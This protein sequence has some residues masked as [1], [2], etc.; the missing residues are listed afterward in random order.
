MST[1]AAAW[2][3][4]SL[5]ALSLAL[6]AFSLLLLVLNLSHPDVPIHPYWTVNTLLAMGFS[7]VGAVI[8]PR[9]SPHNPIGWLFCMVGLLWGV[10]HFSA[11]YAIYTLLAVPG[12]LPASKAAAWMMCWVWVPASGLIVFLLLLCPDGQLP[13][14]RWRLFA[15]FSLLLILVGVISQ[16]L[17]PGSVYYLGSIHNPLGVEGLPNVGE[18]VQTVVFTLIFVSAGSLFVRRLRA[19]GVERQQLKWFAYSSTLAISGVI[20]TYTISDAIG[21]LW[22]EWVGYVVLVVG[23]IGIPISMG[24]AI[25][26]YRLYEIDLL[27]NRT[28]VYGS[29]TAILTALYFGAIVLLQRLFV[30]LTGEKST[31]AVVASTLLIAALFSPLRRRIQSFIDRR[32]YRSK[33]DARKTLDAFSAKLRDETNLDALS[34]DLVGVVRETM[35]PAHVSLWLRSSEDGRRPEGNER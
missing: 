33:Y 25:L 9:I 35:Q 10:T 16:A 3:V 15:W 2:L 18:L 23:F 19:S 31:L 32:F 1:R 5:C 29:L 14:R 24:I 21:A 22:L 20:L 11:Q 13:S 28:L 26:R 34:D 17:A 12:S 27:I 7:P 30:A 6:T 4:W 8:V